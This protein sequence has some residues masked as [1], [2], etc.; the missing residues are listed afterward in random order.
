MG[1][2]HINGLNLQHLEW[3][4]AGLPMVWLTGM[5]HTPFVFQDIIPAFSS[6]FHCFAFSRRGHGRSDAPTDGD[7][8]PQTLAS[9]VLTFLDHLNLTD[10]V[11]VGHSIAGNEMTLAATL[12][13]WRFRAL[14]YLDAAYDR[15][16]VLDRIRKDPL[17][18]GQ[19]SPQP[20]TPEEF[21]HNAQQQYGFWTH[22]LEADLQNMLL[23]TEGRL[24]LRPLA[25]S[26]LPATD[27]HQPDYTGIQC[28]ALAIYALFPEDHP[29][30]DDASQQ[31]VA[32]RSEVMVPWQQASI[33]QF[34]TQCKEGQVLEWSQTHHYFFLSDPQRTVEAIRCFLR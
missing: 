9:D 30:E 23:E 29:T 24:H 25:S 17:Q 3:S 2:N 7:Y 10:V 14:I 27:Q 12:Q 16:G 28:P 31:Q 15:S 26:L 20:H 33:Q 18:S 1:T 8:S 21:R 5:G 34:K 4:P 32:F 19:A 11:L 6:N 13:P 22:A